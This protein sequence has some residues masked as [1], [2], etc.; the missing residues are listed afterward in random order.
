M[1]KVL[2]SKYTKNDI[3]QLFGE[4]LKSHYI[5]RDLGVFPSNVKAS[6]NY[7]DVD[8]F[9]N[10]IERKNNSVKEDE[11]DKENLSFIDKCKIRFAVKLACCI[12]MGLCVCVYKRT[13]ESNFKNNS[14]IQWIKG[15]YRKNYSRSEILEKIEEISKKAYIKYDYMIPESLASSISS[16][17]LEIIKPKILNLDIDKTEEIKSIAVFNE[18]DISFVESDEN[19][20]PSLCDSSECSLMEMD[21]EEIL[22]KNINIAIPVTGT[23]TSIYGAR[24]EVFKNVGYHTGLDI[25]N[26]YNTPIKSATDGVV[27]QAQVLDQYYGNNILIE[28]NGVTFRY[29]HLNKMNI[30]VGDKVTQGQIIGLMGSTGASTGSH[31]HFEIIINGRTVNPEL[32]LN[33]R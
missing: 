10:P 16:N 6:S 31:L 24:D 15:E 33:F 19:V 8:M 21:K 29:A 17:Y 11:N 14:I 13:P 12:F 25:A 22:S 28:C 26:A 32:I 23:I 5:K 27:V 7:Y 18:E 9:G 20:L 30:N 3:K 2:E 1:D 4:E